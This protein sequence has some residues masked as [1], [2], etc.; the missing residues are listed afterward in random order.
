[1]L[2]ILT[3]Q[4]NNAGIYKFDRPREMILTPNMVTQSSTYD[5][6]TGPEKGV[7]GDGNS[8]AHTNCGN[9]ESVWYKIKFGSQ[10]HVR[11][12]KFISV[13]TD[14]RKARMDGTRVFVTQENNEE[15]SATFSIPGHEPGQT[16]SVDCNDML[17]DGVTLRGKVGKTDAC[18]H[19]LEIYVT[20]SVKIGK[21]FTN[22]LQQKYRSGGFHIQKIQA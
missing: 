13:F 21:I 1:M 20:E 18:I 6:E 15:L 16:F 22:F 14:W 9:G 11:G 5:A 10:H 19:M 12:V 17:G 4:E 8:Q 2:M 7:D 3:S